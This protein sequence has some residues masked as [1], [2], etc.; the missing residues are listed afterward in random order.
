MLKRI[1]ENYGK[2][3]CGIKCFAGIVLVFFLFQLDTNMPIFFSESRWDILKATSDLKSILTN[4]IHFGMYMPMSMMIATVGFGTQFCNEWRAGVVPQLVKNIGLK[5]YA[6]L[7]IGMAEL[8]GAII[9]GVGFLMYAVFMRLHILFVN[10]S[11]ANIQTHTI[12]YEFTLQDTTGIQ[13]IF[14]MGLLMT[15]LGA[16]SSVLALCV[17]TVSENRYFVMIAPYLVYR[18]YVE[19]SKI[20][21]IGNKYRLDYYLLGRQ[22]IGES[23]MTFCIIML[24]LFLLVLV[25]GQFVFKQGV[26]RKLIYGK[27]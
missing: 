20:L 6:V 12:L 21:H 26:R 15:F 27:Y 3:L 14:V 13:F 25:I 19:L 4:C 23:I 10:P 8:S 11:A 17:S 7:Y 22:N 2:S 18:I 24:V 5:Q 9:G 1:I 16:L